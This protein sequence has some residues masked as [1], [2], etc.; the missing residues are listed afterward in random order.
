MPTPPKTSHS[1]LIQE[2]QA[3]IEEHGLDALT[4][5]RLAKRAGIKGPSLYKHF[6]DREAL[7][8]AVEVALFEELRARIVEVSETEPFIALRKMAHDFRDFAHK[9]PR[10]YA[11]LYTLRSL[12]SSRAVEVRQRAL[13]PAMVYLVPAFGKEA[14][15]RARAIVA[16]LHGFLSMETAGAFRLGEDLDSA[17]ELGL[18]LVLADPETRT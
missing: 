7:L 8:G 5:S 1:A 6:A 4:M 9:R 11:L 14:F 12:E 17:F 15:L 13:E 16:F 18:D 2:A 3:I 10:C